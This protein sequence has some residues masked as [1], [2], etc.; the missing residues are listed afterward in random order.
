LYGFDCWV[1]V[2]PYTRFDETLAEFRRAADWAAELNLGLLITHDPWAAVNAGRRPS[3]CLRT[4]IELFRRVADLCLARQLR[5]VIEP[6]PDTLSINDAWA[7]DF[8]DALG[9]GSPGGSAGVLYDC[10][11]YGVGQPES[12][13]DA[14]RKLGPRITHVHFA[15]GDAQTYALHLPL[16]DGCLDLDAIVGA[17]RGIGFS[18]TL[19]N[20]LFNYPLLEDGAR[21][22]VERVRA[23]EA[24]LGL[25]HP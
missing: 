12:Y 24:T 10:C 2:D 19:T 5:L 18:G 23:V 21:R 8:I 11:H 15:D 14:V 6:H 22:N 20:D 25:T 17:L 9:E 1:E 4:C 3:H 7:T 13:V 16:G